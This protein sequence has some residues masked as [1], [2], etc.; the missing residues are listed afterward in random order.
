MRLLTGL[1]GRPTTKL[2]YL[3][4]MIEVA[5]RGVLDA[6]GGHSSSGVGDG[7][8]N[9]PGGTSNM[10]HCCSNERWLDNLGEMKYKGRCMVEGRRQIGERGA[11]R[12]V[13]TSSIRICCQHTHLHNDPL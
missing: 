6:D 2:S 3:Q 1:Y 9:E 10:N 4:C 8:G 13:E 7:I 12:Y 11:A 5:V